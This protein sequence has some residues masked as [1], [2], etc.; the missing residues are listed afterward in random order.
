M[1]DAL[2]TLPDVY[3]TPPL[4]I[5]SSFLDYNGHV[6]MAYHVVLADRAL[7]LAFAARGI[8][9]ED[10]PR[11][12]G[13]TTFAAELHTRYLAEI[14]VGDDIRGRVRFADAD[15]K[16][17]LWVVELIRGADGETVTTV[18]GVSLSVSVESRRVA[19]FPSDVEE[20]IT[21]AVAEDAEAVSRFDWLGRS[22]R[23]TKC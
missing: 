12:R 6:N 11:K 20:K 21:A 4:E 3:V 15:A 16:R 23:M 22:V 8:K 14:N 1:S 19:H 18:E 7:D 2:A 9:D 5:E 10:Y 17:V 13:M